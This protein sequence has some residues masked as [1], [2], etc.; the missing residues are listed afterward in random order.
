MPDYGHQ[1]S[2]Q[3]NPQKRQEQQDVDVSELRQKIEKYQRLRDL[4]A[5]ELVDIADRLGS[6]LKNQ[7]LKTSQVRRFLDGVRRIDVQFD[8]GKSFNKDSIILLKPKLAYAAG[9]Q[10]SVKPLM[11][12]LDP[13]I[14]RSTDSYESFKKLLALIEGIMAYHKFHGGGD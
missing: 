1:R 14:S 7:N 3:R 2:S 6:Y 9:R 12:V 4:P 13:A 10:S 8:K 11:D 5:E